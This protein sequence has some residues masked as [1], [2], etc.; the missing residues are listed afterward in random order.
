MQP[1]IVMW[2]CFNVQKIKKKSSTHN[3]GK[4]RQKKEEERANFSKL[5]V[6]GK[7]AWH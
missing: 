2:F 3:E 7:I 1:G 5:F 4:G 6:L